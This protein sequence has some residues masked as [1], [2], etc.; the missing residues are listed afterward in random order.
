MLATTPRR[1][2]VNTP[3][4]METMKTPTRA[5]AKTK[6]KGK[7]KAGILGQLSALWKLLFCFTRSGALF[8]LVKVGLLPKPLAKL[9]RLEGK[10]L[11]NT[12]RAERLR[13]A[14]TKLGGGY[15]KL[16]QALS[17]RPDLVGEET[18]QALSLLQDRMPPLPFKVIKREIEQAFAKNLEDLYSDFTQEAAAAASIAQVH[19]A[20]TKEGFDVAVKVLRPNIEQQFQ[21]EIALT[22]SAIRIAEWRNP[23]LKPLRFQNIVDLYESWVEAEVDL[24]REA[25]SASQLAENMQGEPGFRVPSIDWKRT[26]R[27]VLTLEWINGVRIDDRKALERLGIER[28]MLLERSARVFF[29]QTFRDGFFHADIHPGNL[30]VEPD[31]TMVPVDFGIMGHLSIATRH[32]LADILQGFLKRDY[33]RVAHAYI[34]GGYAARHVD[35]ESLTLACRSVGEPLFGR[36]N[37][38]EVSFAD[39]LLG[40]IRI[41]DKFDIEMQPSLLLLH[42]SMLQGEGVGKLL[43]SRVNIWLRTEPLIEQWLID[44]RNPRTMATAFLRR[45]AR[46]FTQA[47]KNNDENNSENNDGNSKD[48]NEGDL[49]LLRGLRAVAAEIFS[50]VPKGDFRGRDKEKDEAFEKDKEDER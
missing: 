24:R 2:N 11:T 3:Q 19:R 33:A 17:V 8:A 5:Q 30:F 6:V 47:Q 22:R 42:K 10:N 15:A 16:G 40:M 35:I 13:N 7:A 41:G 39:L 26:N 45:L 32:L 38:N 1:R 18:A 4:S 27:R 14:I 28:E 21:R 9:L 31:G 49:S 20:R 29:K 23:H 50:L 44:N 48:N 46:A 25:A 43:D 37:L 36:S 12:Q 34:D